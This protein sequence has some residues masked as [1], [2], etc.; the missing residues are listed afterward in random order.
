MRTS[1]SSGWVGGWLQS[2]PR[3]AINKAVSDPKWWEPPKIRTLYILMV[4]IVAASHE[5]FD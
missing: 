3:P 5:V 1:L 2:P 4:T